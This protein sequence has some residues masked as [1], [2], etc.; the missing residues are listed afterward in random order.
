MT[1]Q[2][3]LKKAIDYYHQE[4]QELNAIQAFK[5]LLEVFPN[6]INGWTHLAT[7]QHKITDFDGAI[8]SINKA[9]DVDPGNA[10]TVKQ[11]GIILSLIARFSSE[12]QMYFDEQTKEAH[13]VKSFESKFDLQKDL[14]ET[15]SK[16]IDLEKENERVLYNYLWQFVNNKFNIGEHEEA[17]NILSNL[18]TKMPGKYRP[19]RRIRELQNIEAGITKNLIALKRYEEAIMRL[20][21]TMKTVSDNYFVGL[22]LAD[23]YS[24][25]GNETEKRK[26]LIEL[27]ES[28]NEKLRKSPELAYLS[29]KFEIMKLLERPEEM[30]EIISDFDLIENQ[31]EFTIK[32][33]NEIMEQIKSYQEKFGE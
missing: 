18:K 19:E 20:N 31:N 17:I 22:T 16:L 6:N 14:D 8:V 3:L 27:L 5:E 26:V 2:E 11:K 28:N 23:V 24:A 7:M 4:G 15:L 30:E 10:N 25:I 33:K 21:E 29:R 9:I 32:R 13:E 12:G 1:E